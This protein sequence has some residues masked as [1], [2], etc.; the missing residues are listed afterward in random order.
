ML[1][2][3]IS[4]FSTRGFRRSLRLARY[5]LKLQR[6][7]RA[8]LRKAKDYAG[9]RDLR[10]NL[11]SGANCKS[12][13]INIDRDPKADLHLDLRENFPFSDSSAAW[14]YSEHFF[15]HLEFPKEASHFLSEC[16]RVLRPGGRLDIGVPDTEWPIKSYSDD[17]SEYFRVARE[18]FHPKWCDTKMHHLNFH[19]RQGNEHK[20]AYDE[21]TLT[22]VLRK[23]QFVEIRRR[24]FDP[25]ID[26]R[27]RAIGTLYLF[28]IKP[29]L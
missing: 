9:R 19:F 2:G 24:D 22:A 29:N 16:F 15:E 25:D 11:G 18:A 20:Y 12:G 13:W 28:A 26:S 21:E 4:P 8:S 27:A 3:L 7:H 17:A 10:L 14:I 23:H 1:G 5:E 6:I